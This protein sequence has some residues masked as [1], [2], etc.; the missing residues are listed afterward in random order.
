MLSDTNFSENPTICVLGLGYVGLPLAVEFGKT[1]KTVG[2]EL[3]EKRVQQLNQ[4]IDITL[5]LDERLLAE[6]KLLS[7]TFDVDEIKA[8]D[9]YIV[10]VPTPIDKNK[11]PDLR[12]LMKASELLG[13]VLT[14]N[15]IVIYE[16]T[17][18]PGVTE[19]ICA[20]ILSEISNL[21]LNKDFYLGYSPERINPGDKGH[22]VSNIVKVT[23]GST[24]EAAEY[25]DQLYAS[26]ITAGTFRASSIKV[27]E[28]AKVI[29]NTQR[30]ITSH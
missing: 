22:R 19:E 28:A 13:K 29:E 11:S 21:Q 1:Y 5:E 6:A 4:G 20:P 15:N 25:I 24:E 3:N 9:I 27:A 12:P 16:S 23:S 8:C 18:Y 2:Y 30:D 26:I 17:V 7:F 14:F 10:T